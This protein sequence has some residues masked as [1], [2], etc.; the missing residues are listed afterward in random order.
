MS[1]AQLPQQLIEQLRDAHSRSMELV[2]GLST[3]QLMG[4]KL[5]IVNPLRWEIGHVAYFH[6][7]WVL[8][9]LDGRPAISRTLTPYTIPSQ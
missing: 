5:K 2:R 8:R 6:E 9:H 4:P 7:F 1:E 3:E